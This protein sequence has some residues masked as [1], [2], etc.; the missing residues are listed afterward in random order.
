MPHGTN[1]PQLDALDPH[2]ELITL[3]TRGNDIGFAELV[4]ACIALLLLGSPC[5]DRYVLNGSNLISER[6]DRTA[7]RLDAAL[8]EIAARAPRTTIVLVGYPSVLPQDYPG[9]WPL[10]PY[11]PSDVHYLRAKNAELNAMLRA[12]SVIHGARYV[13]VFGPSLGKDACAFP[14]HRWVERIVPLSPAF[15]VHLNELGMRAIA[16]LVV[17]ARN[18]G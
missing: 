2:T 12:R 6:I 3:G 1:P 10:M 14:D 9:C 7:E 13:D 15:P 17:Q 11:A 16:E 8:H 4:T 5:Q 18:G